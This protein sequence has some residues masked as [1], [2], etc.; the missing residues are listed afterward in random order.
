[1]RARYWAG[2]R[3][4]E[5]CFLVVAALYSTGRLALESLREREPG[6]GRIALGHTVSVL[7][8]ISALATLIFQWPR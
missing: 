8:V 6:A 7:T 3:S 4:T 1:M 2:C 5:R